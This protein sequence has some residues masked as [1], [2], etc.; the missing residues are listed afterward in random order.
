MSTLAT[1]VVKLRAEVGDFVKSMDDAERQV[2]KFART[3]TNAGRNMTEGLTLPIVGAG[4]LLFKMAADAEVTDRRF[5]LAFGSMA[6][7]A[8]VFSETLATQLGLSAEGIRK[9]LTPAEQALRA[10]GFSAQS[11]TAMSE[12]LV[13]LA[14]DLSVTSGAGRSVDDIMQS[15]TRG[16]AGSARG[17]KD[18]GIVIDQH[19]VKA[20]ALQHGLLGLHET[21]S[22]GTKA[23]ITYQMM[24]QQT[25]N[26]QGSFAKNLN[27]PLVM[28]R[29]LKEQAGDVARALGES[30]MP[31][32]RGILGWAHDAAMKIKELSDWFTALPQGVRDT[33]VHVGLVIAA[34]GPLVFVFGKVV[35]GVAGLISILGLLKNALVFLL[36]NPVGQVILA[37]GILI[38]VII[39]L[40]DYTN[41]MREQVLLAWTS[42]KDA[43][44]TS[45]AFMLDQFATL[46]TKTAT[47][48]LTIS[49]Y[50]PGVA[51]TVARAGASALDGLSTT[52]TSAATGVRASNAQMLAEAARTITRLESMYDAAGR[53]IHATLAPTIAA[54]PAST[55]TTDPTAPG[56]NISNLPTQAQR[57]AEA[58]RLMDEQMRISALGGALLGESYNAAAA[59]A[60]ELKKTFDTI[61]ATGATADQ[62]LNRQGLTLTKLGKQYQD[63]REQA[64][65]FVDIGVI[66]TSQ[67]ASGIAKMAAAFGTALASGANVFKALGDALLGS[68]GSVA[69]AIGTK[70]I[71]MGV[72]IRLAITNPLNMIAA[73]VALVALGAA[74]SSVSQ[75]AFNSS[76]GSGSTSGFDIGTAPVSNSNV[77]SGGSATLTLEISGS[78]FHLNPR[79]TK[80]VDE[81]AHMLETV[82]NRGVGRVKL[83]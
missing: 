70:L 71:E 25:S 53:N 15:L 63:A 77:N 82:M 48:L 32:F 26:I 73:G 30:L 42:V 29:Q 39:K 67:V 54:S 83:G 20:Y 55:A 34:I 81:F 51:G 24:L 43:V 9:A 79:D 58:L 49:A 62:V 45:V 40:S 12:G 18:M 31:A 28:L 75:S 23:F 3:A 1:L 74:L 35:S 14:E 4:A 46:A 36:T 69:T 22:T 5:G 57:I 56:G 59:R 2:G 41:W 52:F 37:V 78:G 76:G 38:A 44:Q 19:A 17:L 6:G 65:R 7:Q 66:L 33:I 80:A 47:F 13:K 72:L 50:L 64:R 8:R 21:M 68:L 10:M 60:D 11:A 61:A 27:D 16:I